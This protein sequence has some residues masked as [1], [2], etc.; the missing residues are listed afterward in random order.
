MKN[1]RLKSIITICMAVVTISTLFFQP[2]KVHAIDLE[3]LVF[4]EDKDTIYEDVNS[5]SVYY[6]GDYYTVAPISYVDGTY[7][8][9]VLISKDKVEWTL[10][11]ELLERSASVPMAKSI[12]VLNDH[13]LVSVSHREGDV[14]YISKD[15]IT[16]ELAELAFEDIVYHSNQYWAID[17][18]GIIYYSKDLF[19][20]SKLTYLAS[21]NT[22]TLNAL[23]LCVTDDLIIVSHYNPKW[24]SSNYKNG[25]E[26]YVMKERVWKEVKGYNVQVGVTR[27]IVWTGEQYI[28]AYQNDYELN[29]GVVFYTSLDGINWKVEE[30]RTALIRDLSV[31]NEDTNNEKLIK[32]LRNLISINGRNGGVTAVLVELD[33]KTIEFDQDAVLKEGRVLVPFRKI[34][35]VLGGTVTWSLTDQK[36]TGQVGANNITLTIGNKTAFFNNKAVTLDVPAVI[37]NGRAL[38]PVRFVADSL[39]KNVEWDQENYIVKIS[40]KISTK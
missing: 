30:N 10:L 6:K 28:L 38:V 24:G 29:A 12:R 5:D 11:S 18:K 17:S 3:P 33:G 26:V 8:S 21:A 40:T 37:I 14:F 2:T 22:V 25:L 23:D 20:W 31:L 35:E 13:F 36:V 7:N 19:N 39:G 1:K 27:E 9:A 34:F 15:G 32:I 4:S 16:W